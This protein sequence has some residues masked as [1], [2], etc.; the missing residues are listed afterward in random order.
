[1]KRAAEREADSEALIRSAGRHFVPSQL[2]TEDPDEHARL[3][4]KLKLIN[5]LNRLIQQLGEGR[6]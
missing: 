3:T 2:R 6:K 1:M 5:K 4:E